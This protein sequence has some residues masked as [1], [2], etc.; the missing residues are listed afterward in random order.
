MLNFQYI[1]QL[2]GIFIMRIVAICAALTTGLT[3][4]TGAALAGNNGLGDLVTEYVEEAQ[5]YGIPF[6]A[7]V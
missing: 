2:K 3:L 1:N 7:A 6:G 5:T 4:T